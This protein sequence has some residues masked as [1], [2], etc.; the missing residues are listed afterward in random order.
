MV[1]K[2]EYD[3]K[4][5]S[6]KLKE[7]SNYSNNQIIG[8]FKNS[9]KKQLCLS[10]CDYLV[11]K[12]YNI[13]KCRLCGIGDVPINIIFEIIDNNLIINGFEYIKK[14]Y[15]YGNNKECCGLKL[16]PN[17]FEF[18]SKINMISIEEAKKLL[19]QNNKSPFY[20]E[21]W[22]SES[23]YKKSQSRSIDYYIKKY[24]NIKG[25]EK[26]QEH[27]NKISISNSLEGYKKKY[28]DF[29]G[30]K[31]FREVS[32]SK[33]SMSLKY[34]LS[35]NEGD[36][37]KAVFEFEDRKMSVN[38]SLNTLISKYGEIDGYKK[39]NERIEKAKITLLSNPNYEKICKSR[40]VTL[41]KMIYNHGIELGN[42]KYNN[43][44]LNT[45]VPICKASKESLNIFE[46]LIEIL[47][48]KYSIKYEDI[49]LGKD[50]KNEFFLKNGNEIFFYD[51][52]IRSKKIIIEYNG[53]AFHPKNE[54]SE[55]I[56]P[57]NNEDAKTA[58]ER[59]RR[60][61]ELAE[62]NGFKVLELWSDET[63]NIEKCIKFINYGIK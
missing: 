23:E 12:G 5:F 6:F 26:Y 18:V 29:E 1:V 16:N 48:E 44:L 54:N 36:Y 22:N 39:H 21:N 46:P 28:G 32:K 25:Q 40:A 55:W 60:K 13:E 35:K 43:W 51:F 47:I 11:Y 27:I 56:N 7:N 59:Q 10:L 3:N 20:K 49:Y 53:V 61:I 41:E 57:F 30:K 9:L 24:G 52:T 50:N 45:K 33:D 14:I 58:F 31:K 8:F 34:F 15:C 62:K 38:I 37:N 63:G 19:K 2:Y 42:I 17:S 4:E